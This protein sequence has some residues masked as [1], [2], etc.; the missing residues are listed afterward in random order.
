MA[1][2]PRNKVSDA[3]DKKETQPSEEELQECALKE[4][5]RR[6]GQHG[7]SMVWSPPHF[8]QLREE[9]KADMDYW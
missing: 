5:D 3:P 1:E 9:L 6:E 8:R 2:K 7:L 4:C